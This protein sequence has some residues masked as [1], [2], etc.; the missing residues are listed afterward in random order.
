MEGSNSPSVQT[1]LSICYLSWPGDFLNNSNT[2][3]HFVGATTKNKAQRLLF[4][5]AA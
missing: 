4:L 2:A 3:F 1:G 5:P